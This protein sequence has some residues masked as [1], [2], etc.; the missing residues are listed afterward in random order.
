MHCQSAWLL[1]TQKNKLL[2]G[3][4]LCKQ[5][6]PYTMQVRNAVYISSAAFAYLRQRQAHVEL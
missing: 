3:D 2:L 6:Q 1:N 5:E 4:K